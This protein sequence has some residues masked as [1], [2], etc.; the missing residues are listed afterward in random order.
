[1]DTSSK[2]DVYRWV[3]S[4]RGA[5]R[6]KQVAPVDSRTSSESQQAF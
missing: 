1:M 3:G 5:P 4:Q 2:S 6:A